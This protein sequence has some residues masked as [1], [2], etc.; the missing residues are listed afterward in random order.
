MM[1]V[2]AK[3][4]L[5]SGQ[6]ESHGH[7]H[8]KPKSKGKGA[9]KEMKNLDKSGSQEVEDVPS[10]HEMLIHPNFEDNEASMAAGRPK[11]HETCVDYFKK[12][13]EQ[14]LKPIL[15]YKYSKERK[16]KQFELYEVMKNKG[17]NIEK[18]YATKKPSY[19]EEKKEDSVLDTIR[20][21][22]P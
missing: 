7:G 21:Q 4:L 5:P 6:E 22:H 19:M 9:S 10:F 3:V 11:K 14:I 12:F 17:Q 20:Q 16:E 18:L 15:I 2:L 1:P 8:A 13:D